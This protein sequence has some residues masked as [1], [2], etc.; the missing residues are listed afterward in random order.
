MS[1]VPKP[2]NFFERLREGVISLDSQVLELKSLVEATK[3][4]A[5][6]KG[7]ECLKQFQFKVQ[8]KQQE[9]VQLKSELLNPLNFDDIEHS[10]VAM[11]KNMNDFIS[12]DHHH[13]EST[14]VKY[15]FPGT[16]PPVRAVPVQADIIKH[17]H[18]NHKDTTSDLVDVTVEF[19]PGLTT[20]RPDSTKKASKKRETMRPV[21]IF[22]AEDSLINQK[23]D[24]CQP[25]VSLTPKTRSMSLRKNV[26]R[27]ASVEGTRAIDPSIISKALDSIQT[28][29][30]Q[31]TPTQPIPTKDLIK[32]AKL[33]RSLKKVDVGTPQL[34]SSSLAFNAVSRTLRPRK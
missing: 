20:K 10:I 16:P 7:A 2:P 25:V 14:F 19:T 18:P 30:G 29:L 5:S 31:S 6:S 1:D 15:N 27:A 28:N 23:D 32:T 21:K 24:I 11:E 34:P 12:G 13:D 33:V 8:D 3:R 17:Q 26:S 4:Q 22:Q 9:M